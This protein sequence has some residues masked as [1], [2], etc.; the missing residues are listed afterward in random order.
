MMVIKEGT[1]RGS[2]VQ[3][4]CFHWFFST[5]T[6]VRVFAVC[7]CAIC[8]MNILLLPYLKGKTKLAGDIVCAHNL[9]LFR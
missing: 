6:V 4:R 2:R 9:F 1:I 7:E 3:K 5:I 8:C